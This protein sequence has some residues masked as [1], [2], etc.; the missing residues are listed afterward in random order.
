MM[1]KESLF[2]RVNTLRKWTSIEAIQNGT[3]TLFTTEQ[4]RKNIVN[5]N[6]LG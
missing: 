4:V 1:Q 6:N 3:A 2:M 5:A